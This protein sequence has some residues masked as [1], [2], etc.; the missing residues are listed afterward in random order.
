MSWTV[1]PVR[2][3][4][5]SL[6]FQIRTRT[7]LN[8]GRR[9]K[10]GRKPVIE[11]KKN[12]FK[13]HQRKTAPGLLDTRTLLPRTALECWKIPTIGKYNNRFHNYHRYKIFHVLRWLTYPVKTVLFVRSFPKDAMVKLFVDGLAVLLQRGLGSLGNDACHRIHS[14]RDQKYYVLTAPRS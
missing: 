10:R 9:R 4:P 2:I 13:V 1:L 12:K 8:E 5:V 6:V 7:G 3:P 11:V 14:K